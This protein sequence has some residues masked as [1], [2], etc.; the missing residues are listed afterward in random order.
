MR[1]PYCG[2]QMEQGMLRANGNI[3]WMLKDAKEPLI[4]SREKYEKQKAIL[5]PPYWDEKK[6]VDEETIALACFSCRK[7]IVDFPSKA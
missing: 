2:K 3:R 7:M 6:L 1:C 4:F 5:F